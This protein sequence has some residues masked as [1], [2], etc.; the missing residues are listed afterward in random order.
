MTRILVFEDSVYRRDARGVHTDQSFLLFAARLSA[1][2]DVAM[3]GRL[4]PDPG[5][6]HYLLPSAV[7]FRGLPHYESLAGAA[8]VVAALRS[9]RVLWAALGEADV[10]WLLGPHPLALAA[11]LLAP[12]RG[13]RAVLGVRQDLPT[14][15]RRRHPGRR[16]IHLAADVLEAAWRALARIRPVV[17]VGP[18]LARRYAHAPRLLELAVSLVPG[19]EASRD[20]AGGRSPNGELRLLSVGRLEAEKNPLLL[21][22]VLALLRADDPR[23]RLVVCGEGPLAADL[24]ARLREAGLEH[25]AELRGYVPVDA[26]LLDAYRASDVFLHVSWTE[27]VPQVLFEAWAAGV[28]VAATAV[29]GVT[30]VA[31]GAA[32]LVPPGDAAAAAAAVRRLARDGELRAG[33]VAAGRARA[34]AT[35]MEESRAR[36]AGFL[37]GTGPCAA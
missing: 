11:A 22:D 1:V 28:P 10:A 8:A 13:T 21:A 30:A 14:Y 5:A 19:E 6:S 27:G 35:T 26:G 31:E 15:A 34:A 3:L 4:H 12:L 20:G 37:R 16:R 2:A 17:V 24:E 9:L 33:L 25:A 29:G 36:L 32:L 18:D 23:W 7:R